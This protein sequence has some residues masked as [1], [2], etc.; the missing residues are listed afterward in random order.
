VSL[1][2]GER[3][4]WW[5]VEAAHS[6]AHRTGISGSFASSPARAVVRNCVSRHKSV[7]ASAELCKDTLHILVLAARYVRC[8]YTGEHNTVEYTRLEEALCLEGR[9]LCAQRAVLRYAD[10]LIGTILGGKWFQSGSGF[11]CIRG[12]GCMRC[13]SLCQTGNRVQ[14]SFNLITSVPA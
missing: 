14:D 9:S 7:G 4:F 2:L 1:E 10:G 6:Y 11:M 12:A 3:A 8:V 13:L 5:R